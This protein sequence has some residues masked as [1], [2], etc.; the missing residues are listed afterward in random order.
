M[1]QTALQTLLEA[2]VKEIDGALVIALVDGLAAD[3]FALAARLR[4]QGQF[5]RA[6]LPENQSDKELEGLYFAL[7]HQPADLTG[8]V[9]EHSGLEPVR[10]LLE[11]LGFIHCLSSTG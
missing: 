4:V 9:V 3:R 5:E 2:A 11:E 10:K 1:L 6:H 8:Q 7:P